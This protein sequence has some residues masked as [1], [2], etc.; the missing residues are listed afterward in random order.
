MDPYSQ[1]PAHAQ[2]KQQIKFACTYQEIR[3]GDVLPSIRALAEQLGVG[4]GVVRRAYRELCEIGFLANGRRRHV[5]VAPGSIAAS[6]ADALVQECGQQCEQ[7]I[8]WGR[9]NRLSVIALG[10]VLLR[11]AIMLETESPS[12]VF[13]DVCRLAAEESAD[14]V[15][16]AW[17]IRV[18]GLSAQDFAGLSS[19]GA[20]RPSVV[21]VNQF[22]YEDVMAAAGEMS[23]GVFPVAMRVAE[24]LQRRILKLPTS[25]RVLLVLADDLFPQTGRAVL[26]Y[27]QHLFGRQWRFDAKPVGSI[28]ELTALVGSRRYGLFLLSPV[29]WEQTPPRLRRSA[30]VDRMVD[31]PDPR[32]LEETRV[33]AGVLM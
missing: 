7:L 24:R 18:T 20:R 17:E 22:L 25:S 31:E 14:K 30:L 3:P 16:K 21:L 12:Y 19:A 4:A 23:R 1:V 10:R 11:R 32:S 6:D 28:P 9:E 13:V 2:L 15:A 8:A 26:R 29:V 33:A 5:V 27:Y